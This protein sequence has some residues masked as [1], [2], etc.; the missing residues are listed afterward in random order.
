MAGAQLGWC[1]LCVCLLP[2]SR[3]ICGG[4][5]VHATTAKLKSANI[6]RL[7]VYVY[8]TYDDTLLNHQ[9]FIRQ[10]FYFGGSGPNLKDHQCFRLYGIY[11]QLQF[12]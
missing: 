1:M 2:Y 4:L 11:A 7:H 8:N 3:K 5:A 6:S 10:Y 9:I 12:A